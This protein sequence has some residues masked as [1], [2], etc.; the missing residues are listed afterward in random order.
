MLSKKSGSF[1]SG[2]SSDG[3][4]ALWISLCSTAQ[5]T[6]IAFLRHPSFRNNSILFLGNPRGLKI[7][8]TFEN[9]FRHHCLH[10]GHGP[11]ATP[12][13][14]DNSVP[15]LNA[16]NC[17]F[18]VM[19]SCTAT[20]KLSPQEK[21][22]FL[23]DKKSHHEVLVQHMVDIHK[24]T[25]EFREASERKPA[26]SSHTSSA[27]KHFA[28]RSIVQKRLS[29]YSWNPGPRRGKEDAFEIELQEGGNLIT[30]QEVSEYVVHELLTNR[31][32]V[33]H[34]AGCAIL[35]NEDAFYPNVDVKSIFF[36]DTRRDLPD[37]VMDGEHGWVMQGVLSRASFR[38]SPVSGHKY[39]TV[40]SLHICNIYAKKRGIAQKLILTIRAIMISQEVDLVAGDF[41]GTAWRYR[42]KDNRNTIDEAF[43]DCASPTPPGS[44]PL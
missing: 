3:H 43:T 8:L 9:E 11:N 42:S 16:W 41:S 12:F 14:H 6:V 18:Q 26:T 35:F 10:Y 44:T 20:K 40:F 38:R 24:A 23:C 19:K 21:I 31:F 32:H 29:I 39:F 27:N 15:F 5:T 34:Y 25:A 2:D 17:H 1:V 36:H 22:T 7:R 30:L 33:T 4:R 28:T 13:T 37:Q